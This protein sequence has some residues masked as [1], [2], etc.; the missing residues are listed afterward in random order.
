[1][2]WSGRFLGKRKKKM[3]EVNFNLLGR[4]RDRSTGLFQFRFIMDFVFGAENDERSDYGRIGFPF[5]K[6]F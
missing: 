2:E 6:N 3:K 1:M 4:E 5:V